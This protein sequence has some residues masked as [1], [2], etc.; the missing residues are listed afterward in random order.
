MQL[1]FSDFG[2]AFTVGY[3]M[4]ASFIVIDWLMVKH[5]GAPSFLAPSRAANRQPCCH[6][7]LLVRLH[8]QPAPL[9]ELLTWLDLAGYSISSMALALMCAEFRGLESPYLPGM[10]LVLFAGA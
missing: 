8:R 2:R 6:S 5:L 10:C 1:R 4:W 9:L 3:A 7:P